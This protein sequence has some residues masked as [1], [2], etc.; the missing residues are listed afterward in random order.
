MKCPNC[1]EELS[2]GVLFCRE[3]G[4]KIPQEPK[5]R[6]CR[7]CG[8]ELE[9]NAK[10]CSACGAKVLTQ[11]DVARPLIMDGEPSEENV[12]EYSTSEGTASDSSNGKNEQSKAATSSVE[13]IGWKDRVVAKVKGVCQSQWDSF[14]TYERV[15][16]IAGIFFLACFLTAWIAD[17]PLAVMAS[18]IQLGAAIIL[19]LIHRGTIKT[20]E[21]WPNYV[22]PVLAVILCFSYVSGFGAGKSKAAGSVTVAETVVTTAPQ[23]PE[24]VTEETK[25]ALSDDE[26]RIDFSAYD[27]M[28]QNYKDVAHRLFRL[29][30]TNVSYRVKY[31]IVFGITSEGSVDSVSIAGLTDY[32]SGDVFKKNDPV[33]I[34]YHMKSA[35]D[36]NRA[37]ETVSKEGTAQTEMT[38]AETSPAETVADEIIT[39]DN[40]EDFKKLLTSDYLDTAAQSRFASK[41]K[42]R[43][44]EFDGFVYYMQQNPKYD[45]I[46]SYAFMPGDSADI[47]GCVL[48]GMEDASFMQFKWDSKTRPSYLSMGSKI[49][50]R[51]EITGSN[52]LYIE[53]KPVCTWGR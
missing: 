29:G 53:V 52:E 49:R 37:T 33:F 5:K 48:F 38:S 50:M 42:N 13:D 27:L 39:I 10:F 18:F 12:G 9:P 7:E 15:Y 46:W 35:D 20:K 4:C 23:I 30:F 47:T 34:T 43:I 21:R 8:H 1:G 41:Y 44:I 17:K 31:D 45:T 19:Y 16:V 24:S 11:E 22:L 28:Y 32:S 3:C 14:D 25:N 51:A 36:P 2:D 6:F 26:T 40:N